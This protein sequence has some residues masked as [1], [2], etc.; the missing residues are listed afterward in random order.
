MPKYLPF[1]SEAW[2]GVMLEG[3]EVPGGNLDGWLAEQAMRAW[4]KR[5]SRWIAAPS[6]K[7]PW[8]VKVLKSASDFDSLANR[9]KWQ[10]R[11]S[12]MLHTWRISQELQAEGFDC[13]EIQLA[14]RQRRWEPLGWPT[15][16]LVSSPVP[17]RQVR[18]LLQG[19]SPEAILAAVAAELARFH[20]AGFAHGDCIPGNLFLQKNGRLAF[21]DND[22][23][24]RTHVWDRRPRIRRNL[25]QFAFH[26]LR[27]NQVSCDQAQEFL[28]KYVQYAKWPPDAAERELT[29]IWQWVARR[30]A[31]ESK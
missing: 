15:D 9:L 30:L 11:P 17:G 6:E 31:A 5:P 24:M 12:R 21:I 7:C 29:R 28:F 8:Y 16:V 20:A 13:P 26:L 27:R 14:A 22:R 2:H 10:L 3:F 18:E 4:L 19:E 23:T 1:H 25:V